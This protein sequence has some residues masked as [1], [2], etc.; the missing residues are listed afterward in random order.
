M[1]LIGFQM[2][3]YSCIYRDKFGGLFYSLFQKGSTYLL[4]KLVKAYNIRPVSVLIYELYKHLDTK[5]N[6]TVTSLARNR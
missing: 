4:C 3:F 1:I 5:N 6:S 2:V